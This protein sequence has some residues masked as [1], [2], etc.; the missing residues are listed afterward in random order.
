MPGGYLGVSL[1][2]TLSG[3]VIGTVILHE[4]ETRGGFSLTGFWARRGRR[5]LPAAWVVLAVVAVTR[6]T[7]T[8]FAST[9][10]GDIVA[11][12]LQVANWH[13]LSANQSYGALFAGPSAVLHFWSLAIEEQFYV[14][15]G[16]GALLLGRLGR[17]AA[18][19]LVV[20]ATGLAIVSFALPFVFGMSVDRV[21]YGTDT[22]AG[23]LLVGLAL[24][25]VI[26]DRRRRE[27][28]LRASRPIAAVALVALVGSVA[29][30]IMLD[31]GTDGLRR[32][33]LPLTALASTA[34]VLGALVPGPVRVLAGVRP[35]RWLGGISYALYLIHWPV[36][37]ALRHADPSPGV[38]ADAIAVGVAVALA[39]LSGKFVET[40]VRSRQLI[41]RPLALGAG[42]LAVGLAVALVV[43]TQKSASQDLLDRITA[44]AAAPTTTT[45]VIAAT[46]PTA[47]GGASGA[48]APTARPHVELLGD[49][50]ALSLAL[51]LGAAA[52]QATFDTGPGEFEIGCG[53]GPNSNVNGPEGNPC[54]AL[55]DRM[56]ADVAA[57]HIDAVVVISCQWELLSQRLPG[58][59]G[60]RTPGDPVFD[61]YVHD[62]YRDVARRLK[63]AG[64]KQVL[65]ARCPRLST[66]VRPD[67]LPEDLLL[68]RDP[69]RVAAIDAVVDRLAAE[70]ELQTLDLA[71]WV[72]ARI[73]DAALRPD[74]AHFEWQH[75]TGVAAELTRL[76]NAALA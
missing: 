10:A 69:A 57:R 17:R 53:V 11:S 49:S 36:L 47:A 16:L 63:A 72:D 4:I 20:A 19:G 70:G 33:L 66:N 48:P 64:A 58:E 30:W 1:F 6:V 27:V 61:A 14:V 37:V 9:S 71:S 22:R 26:A 41:G 76:I 34:L 56:V 60:L 74:G 7:T 44:A 3:T 55:I 50:I 73:D 21:Y 54:S 59:T 23:E 35:L 62:H 25:A 51:G 67:D 40:P 45:S 29:M 42:A 52:G 43:P 38:L 18:P 24:A 68:S 2:F 75:D 65:W 39:W 46:P 32:G 15:V 31:A 28:L 13:F 5:L 12:W 8:V